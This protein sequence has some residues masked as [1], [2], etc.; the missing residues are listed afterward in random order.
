MS[1]DDALGH[2]YELAVVVT[3]QCFFA[4]F[5][6]RFVDVIVDVSAKYPASG[7]ETSE[8]CQ[9]DVSSWNSFHD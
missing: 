4:L 5:D 7:E 3:W 1:I 9:S 2:S 6:G 8:K